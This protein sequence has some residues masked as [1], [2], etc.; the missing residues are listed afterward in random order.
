MA[1][2][3]RLKAGKQA[4]YYGVLRVRILDR[5]LLKEWFGFFN[6]IFAVLLLFALCQKWVSLLSKAVAGE[7]SLQVVSM[8]LLLT[9]P[10]LLTLLLPFSLFL[11]LLFLMG[12]ISVD[13]ERIAMHTLGLTPFHLLKVILFPAS[14]VAAVLCGLTLFGM[15]RIQHFKE[16][17]IASAGQ[18]MMWQN[19][20]AGRFHVTPDGNTV[21]YAEKHNEQEKVEE[22][23]YIF[24]APKGLPAVGN[25]WEVVSAKAGYWSYQNEQS[26]YLILETGWRYEGVPGNADYV[27]LHFDRFGRKIA[28]API[29][30]P[31]LR[32]TRLTKNLIDSHD[33]GDTAELQYRL[34]LPLAALLL[35]MLAV[36]LGA[37]QP[38]QGKFAR[39]L[40][41]ILI[42]L[43][44]L[45]LLSVGR[46]YVESGAIPYWVGLGAVHLL[47]ILS[48]V[49]LWRRQFAR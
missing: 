16:E 27:R 14:V 13:N 43:F 33:L 1:I 34:S 4:S 21:F 28:I 42:F 49:T 47:V 2:L 9:I 40:P 20:V 3:A 45:N 18:A 8:I 39:L 30:V 38:R 35:A 26:P 7:L 22:G 46:R 25:P 48:I 6:A 36:P 37:T 32:R 17:Y 23:I 10:E 41:G 24:E 11:S 44:Y 29:A 31:E 15:P 5:Y 19:R 12:R